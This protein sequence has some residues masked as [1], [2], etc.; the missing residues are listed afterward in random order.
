MGAAIKAS[1]D[2]ALIRSTFD[3]PADQK[4]AIQNAMNETF[5]ADVRIRYETTPD[6]V[7]GIE[8]TAGGQKIAWTITNYLD[9]LDE[10]VG[11]LLSA[12]PTP[13]AK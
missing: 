1:A 7:C 12:Q 11:Q 9:A 6:G 10:K 3:Q 4:A 5:S 13:E 8:L 2:P